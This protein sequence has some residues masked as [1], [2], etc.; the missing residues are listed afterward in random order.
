MSTVESEQAPAPPVRPGAD[1]DHPMG[2][3]EVNRQIAGWIGRLGTIWIDGQVLEV[4]VRRSMTFLKLK[5]LS[6]DAVLP[7]F[8]RSPPLPAGEGPLEQGQ[9]VRILAK[10]SFWANRG[11]F[12][13]EGRRAQL[14]GLGSWLAEI[15]KRTELL[16]A[17]GLFEDARKR[18]LPFLPNRVGLICGRNSDAEHDVVRNALLRWPA[19]EFELRHVAVQGARAASEV[20]GAL[21]ALDAD[22]AVDVIV[23]ARGGGSIEDLFPFSD[24]A[25]VRA[26]SAAR[27]PVVS[28]IGHEKDSPILDLVA[29]LRASTPTDAGKRV[30]PDITEEVRRLQD[31]RGRTRRAVH[32]RLAHEQAQLDARRSRPVLQHPH[33]L[34]DERARVVAE[35][36][37][38]AR[39]C[40]GAT[41]THDATEVAGL[42]SRVLA[43]SPQATLDRGYAVVQSSDGTVVRAPDQTEP[44]DPLRIRVAHGEFPATRTGGTDA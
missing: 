36:C 3:A 30:V 39:R 29:D 10:P 12:Q 5:D 11:E 4:N 15:H 22:P 41:I 32:A 33:V 37:S 28:A 7:F 20:I 17:E 27:T 8:F 26:V 6:A 25:L 13:M 19:V 42:R 38:R 18:P 16:A 1:P 40:I 31:L 34:V 2:V 21:V 44:G 24:E 14:V 23:I 9:R 35:L 43:L